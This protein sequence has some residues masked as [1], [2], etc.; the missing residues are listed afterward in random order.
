MSWVDIW[1]LINT[2]WVFWWE[3]M[4]KHGKKIWLKMVKNGRIQEWKLDQI[5][6]FYGEKCG[7]IKIFEDEISRVQISYAWTKGV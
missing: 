1:D 2:R 4:V 3:K 5:F 6:S 7:N